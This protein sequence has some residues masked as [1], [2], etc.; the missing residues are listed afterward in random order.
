MKGK[1]CLAKWISFYDKFTHLFDQGKTVDV[2]F[3]GSGKNSDTISNSIL[4]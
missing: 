1:S 3:F 4:F 2:I